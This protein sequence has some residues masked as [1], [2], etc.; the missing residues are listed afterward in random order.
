VRVEPSFFF[1]RTLSDELG[2]PYRS[3]GPLAAA[4]RTETAVLV[5]SHESREIVGPLPNGRHDGRRAIRAGRNL[6]PAKAEA[7]MKLGSRRWA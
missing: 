4:Q 2:G 3:T 6:P 5:D 7:L 1:Q